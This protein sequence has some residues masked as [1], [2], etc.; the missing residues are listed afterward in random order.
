MC[1]QIYIKKHEKF[2]LAYIPGAKAFTDAPESLAMLIKQRRRW[3]N[4][5]MFGTMKTIS[6]FLN[7]LSWNRTKHSWYR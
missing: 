5:A 6:N 2:Y 4:G 3:M 7:M 1:L